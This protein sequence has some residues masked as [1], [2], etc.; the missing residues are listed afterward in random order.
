MLHFFKLRYYQASVIQIKQSIYDPP[1]LKKDS[2]IQLT[3]LSK[4]YKIRIL[5]NIMIIMK[6]PTHIEYECR[7]CK[8]IIVFERS[9]KNLF[10][11]KCGTF[12][13]LRRQPQHWLFQFNPAVYRWFDWVKENRETE[14]WLTIQ[15]AQHI[16]T[17]D[18]IVIWAA[19]NIAGI[20]AIG[21]ILENPRIQSFNIQ[22]KK[23]WTKKAINECKF[24]NKK[25]VTVKYL[26]LL[27][28]KPLL[29]TKCIKD[30]T[31]STMRIFKQA[32]GTNFPLTK[33]QWNRI[34]ELISMKQ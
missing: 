5:F 34:L 18:K 32:Q 8:K 4:Y 13:K 27:V 20:Y 16:Q 30:P 10:C 26:K 7:K 17:G 25:S 6:D 2:I 15:H 3:V 33:K 12:L 14:Q 23:Y 31:L 9:A 11:P 1:H 21:E 28:D 19:G 24:Q 22:Q 29:E